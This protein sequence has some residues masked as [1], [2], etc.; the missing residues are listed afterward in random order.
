MSKRRNSRKVGYVVRS[1]INPAAVRL[2][3][4]CGW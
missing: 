1:K 4:K 3:A 2:G